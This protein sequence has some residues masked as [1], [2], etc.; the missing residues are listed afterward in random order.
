MHSSPYGEPRQDVERLRSCLDDLARRHAQ[1]AELLAAYLSDD[2]ML[3]DDDLRTL[4]KRLID[5]V[6]IGGEAASEVEFSE[7]CLVG[8]KLEDGWRWFACG[9]LLR[10]DLVVTADHVASSGRIPDVVAVPTD[11]VTI[12]GAS[13]IEGTFVREGSSDIAAMRLASS[14][15]VQ[16]VTR[17]STAE[18]DAAGTVTV[19]GF[20]SHA[21]GR[22]LMNRKRHTVLD[23]HHRTA[24]EFIARR[25]GK[26]VCSGD[27]G[28]P[29]YIEVS[30]QRLLAGITS[31]P[32]FRNGPCG[33]GAIFTRI[34]A[35]D[36]FFA[37]F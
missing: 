14:A 31:R 18:I 27:S 33:D 6:I 9:V 7:C 35:H 10:P 20:G 30:G 15:G 22:S 25:N 8:Q 5:I 12:D 26:G 2:A 29:A 37:Q 3:S 28:G 23:V 21:I 1:A 36:A 17:A 34:D 4:L 13:I 32:E 24:G 16:G 19:V 11:G